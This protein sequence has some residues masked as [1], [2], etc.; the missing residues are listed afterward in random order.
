MNDSMTANPYST[1]L[2]TNRSTNRSTNVATPF[3]IANDPQEITMNALASTATLPVSRPTTAE[4]IRI[5]ARKEPPMNFAFFDQKTPEWFTDARCADGV[6]TLAYLFFS[7]DLS[8]IA[9][10]KAICANCPVRGSCLEAAVDRRE[11]W[12]VWG[13]ELV[14]NGKILAARRGRGRPPKVARPEV[15][16]DELGRVIEVE[17]DEVISA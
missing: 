15:V 4:E 11:P 1:N 14:M 5:A 3:E 17:L 12:G 13:G 6:G 9:R 10:A 8:E 2:A 7:E 16:I